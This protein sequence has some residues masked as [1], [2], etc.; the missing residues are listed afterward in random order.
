MSTLNASLGH[1]VEGRAE[2][3]RD[4]QRPV[5]VRDK[6]PRERRSAVTAKNHRESS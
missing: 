3:V 2:R 4:V 5:D 1:R 6:F